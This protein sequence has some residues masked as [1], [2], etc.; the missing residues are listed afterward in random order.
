MERILEVVRMFQRLYGNSDIPA[1][2]VVLCSQPIKSEK[3]GA[4]LHMSLTS[5]D[6]L[7]NIEWFVKNTISQ[8]IANL[9]EQGGVDPIN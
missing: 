7:D 2:R 8:D 1:L 4:T 6:N 3:I 9:F 5:L